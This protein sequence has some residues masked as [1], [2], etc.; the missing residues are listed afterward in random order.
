MDLLRPSDRL[1]AAADADAL[2]VFLAD[3]PR[4]RLKPRAQATVGE[5]GST[6]VT[7]VERKEA[8]PLTAAHLAGL[9]ELARS[10]R[11]G[12][13]VL[14]GRPAGQI[15][16]VT[17]IF[18]STVLTDRPA[19]AWP[20]VENADG[21]QVRLYSARL[22]QRERLLW[23][24]PAKEPRL[25]YPESEKPL[26]PGG[27]YRWQ[28]LAAGNASQDREVVDSTFTCAA[29]ESL[30]ELK[31]LKPLAASNDP[32]DWVLAAAAYDVAGCCDE[33]LA[34]YERLAER[35]PDAAN[36]QVALVYYY[37]R[38]GRTEK[39]KAAREK[40]RKLGADITDEE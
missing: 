27:R 28:V 5:K 29:R 20:V 38:A 18:E 8:A 11:A 26:A 40:A 3:G 12:V 37:Q 31:R 16:A 35:S 13:D 36:V 15:P 23:K 10:G 22:G 25:A 32:A 2:L 24:S 14:R 34:L 6:P 17:P 30:E 9:R 39:A 19:L 1:S 33:A 21:Y 7:A 4:E